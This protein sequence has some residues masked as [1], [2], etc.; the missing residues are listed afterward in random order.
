MHWK[1]YSYNASSRYLGIITSLLSY[2]SE[3]TN[4]DRKR[5]RLLQ[6]T[7]SIQYPHSAPI[8]S[9][10]QARDR[11][12]WEVKTSIQVHLIVMLLPLR[13]L[14][15]KRRTTQ[16]RCKAPNPTRTPKDGKARRSHQPKDKLRKWLVH[17]NQR[18]FTLR[19]PGN[20][21]TRCLTYSCPSTISI[22]I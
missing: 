2:K 9:G 11:Q 13:W 6:R 17:A 21:I 1:G 22:L 4:A 5:I 19:T 12:Q 3:K 15:R 14:V 10:K 8:L 18:T 20:E 16:I 7:P